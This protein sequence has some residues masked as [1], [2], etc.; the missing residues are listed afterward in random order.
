MPQAAKERL[1]KATG[2]KKW[3]QRLL[4]FLGESL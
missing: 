3:L 2:Q 1:E 4:P